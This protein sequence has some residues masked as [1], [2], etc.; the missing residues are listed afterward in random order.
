MYSPW[1]EALHARV[2]PARRQSV[3]GNTNIV[4]MFLSPGCECGAGQIF[5]LTPFSEMKEG[6]KTINYKQEIA[7]NY[8]LTHNDQN[9]KLY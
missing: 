4:E 5:S 6:E 2:H 7:I 1:S 3:N 9:F 8:S